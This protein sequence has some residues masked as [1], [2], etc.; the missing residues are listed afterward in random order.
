MQVDGKDVIIRGHMHLPDDTLSGVRLEVD[1]PA[2][3]V[4]IKAAICDGD[5]CN[6][7]TGISAGL[8]LIFPITALAIV[9]YLA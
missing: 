3:D 5:R 9:K 6:A 2:L 1:Y 4:E 7:A 8:A